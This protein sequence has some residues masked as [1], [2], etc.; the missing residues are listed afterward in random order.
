M[1]RKNK[2]N[3]MMMLS[4][5]TS[6][7]IVTAIPAFGDPKLGD[8]SN[9]VT[10]T[11]QYIIPS[12]TSFMV[13]LCGAETQM[14][15]NPTNKNSKLV[16]P[17]CQSK[18]SNQPWANIANVGNVNENFSA[19]LTGSNPSWVELSIGNSSSMSD[20]V[21][22]TDSE[23]SPQG[24]DNVA[25]GNTVQLYAQANFTDATSGTTSKQMS[26]NVRQY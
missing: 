10:Y 7:L 15:F 19:N 11:V 26:I 2:I 12:D 24:W 22:V 5:I 21:I 13:T 23:L 3:K 6:V 14:N 9:S 8:A 18:M 16:E 25:P 4:L 17:S 20:N 1:L